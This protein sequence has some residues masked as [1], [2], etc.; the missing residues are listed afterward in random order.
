MGRSFASRV[1]HPRLKWVVLVLW[2]VLAAAS[3][4]LA[5]GLTDE[6]EN[7]IAAWLPEDAE[8]TQVLR[9]QAELGSDPD[10]IPAVV[11]YERTEGVT[12]DDAA[13]VAQ[14]AQAFGA[15]EELDGAVVGPIPSEDGQALQLIVPLN[16]GADGWEAIAPLVDGI[17]AEASDGPD[18]LA[19]YVTGPA[20]SAADSSEAFAGIDGTLL[21]AALGVV[22]VILLFTYRSPVLWILPIFSAV[23][24][25]FCAQAV[26]YLL[27]R[28]ADLTVNAQSASI[29][30]VLV[31]GAGTDYALLLVARYR[32]ELRLHADRHEAMTEAVHRAGPAVLASGGT[33]VLG[34][35]CLVAAQMNSTA[36]LGP[37]AAI[38]VAVTLVVLMTLLPALLVICGRWVF[39]PVRPA[40][41]SAEPSATGLWAR[42][43]RLIAPRPRATWVVTSVLLLLA[44]LA[45]FRLDPS[46]LTQAES[47]RGTPESIQG[48]QVAARHFPAVA[49][50][51]VTVVTGADAADEVARAVADTDGIAAVDPPQVSGDAALV[52]ASLADPVD[53]PAAYATVDRLRAALDDVG[54]GQAL[55]GGNTALNLDVQNA[56][57]RDNRVVIPLIMLVVLVVL[58]LL[59]RALVA[60][61][62]LVA[63]VVLSFG[64]ALGLSALVFDWTL[65]ITDTDSSFPLF[66]FVFLVALGIDYNIFLMTRV[67]EEAADHGT[68]RA[69]LVGLAAT[70]GVITSAGLVLAATFAVLGTLPL[71]FLTQLGIAVALGVLLDTIVVRSVL[72]TAL[73]LDVGRRMWWP[74]R[75]T[76]RL[77][78]PGPPPGAPVPTTA[79]AGSAVPAPRSVPDGG[80]PV[81]GGPPASGGRPPGTGSG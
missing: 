22:I 2:L 31:V 67:R 50:N 30:T 16:V 38:G 71:T 74:S 68:R 61:V 59:L 1:S 9:L 53:S 70:G 17:R 54:D 63:T 42:V 19:A 73:T 81:S 64:A 37:V 43:G 40:F 72:V 69:A 80:A 36:G 55:V 51:P 13:A 21:F 58:G 62:L 10:V 75:L 28:Y 23:I 44:C 47:F 25:L 26:V 12:A 48:D 24:A 8:S 79:A 60:P 57:Q 4:P 3:A 5:G 52:T 78:E 41:G 66:V 45:V 27:A 11:V 14:D 20:G 32:E 77:D 76:R 39:W 15:L 49:G 7:D 33:V 56:S 6:Q 29:L 65:G 34:M 18:G 35:L 46:G